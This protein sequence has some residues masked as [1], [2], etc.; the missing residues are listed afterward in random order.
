M[1]YIIQIQNRMVS[2]CGQGLEPYCNTVTEPVLAQN[3][4]WYKFKVLNYSE[5]DFECT[6]DRMPLPGT[7]LR[8]CTICQFLPRSSVTAS[9]I[10][11]RQS[12]CH[13]CIQGMWD[14]ACIGV[15]LDSVSE[16][17]FVLKISPCAKRPHSSI[18]VQQ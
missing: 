3:G 4:P 6:H 2:K 10:C 16:N 11:H 15:E 5:Q 17:S 1:C 14:V 18:H 8:N 13:C 12:R 7:T 9:R